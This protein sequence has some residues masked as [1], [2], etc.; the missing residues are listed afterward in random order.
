MDTKRLIGIAL[1]VVFIVAFAA[2]N[3]QGQAS[4]SN[5]MFV[6]TLVGGL[7][8]GGAGISWLTLVRKPP[9]KSNS[10]TDDSKLS[11]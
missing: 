2:W 9:A 6:R 7:L 3:L 1:I 11:H 5:D 8:A 4:G 10:A